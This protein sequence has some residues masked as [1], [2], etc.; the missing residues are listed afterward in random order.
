MDPHRWWRRAKK[1]CGLA[2]TDSIPP[3]SVEGQLHV[4][5]QDRAACLNS[6]FAS[7]CSA[8]PSP[9]CQQLCAMTSDVF[10]FKSLSEPD[11]LKKL[12]QLD[13]SKSPGM[14]CL[15]N[16]VLKECA[17]TLVQP[18]TFMFNLSLQCGT[19]P[20]R[21]KSAIIQPIFKNRG[22]RSSP[23]SYRP[24]ALLPAVSKV[25]ERLVR[26]QL[27]E[28]C[29]A[30]D[31]IPECQF[32]FLP[33]RSTV[34]QLLAVLEEWED[35][36]DNGKTVHS[37]FL[38]VAKAFDRVDHSLLLMKLRSIGVVGAPLSWMTSYLGNRCIS[39]RV[40]GVCLTSLP[41]SS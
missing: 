8:P 31:A 38:D 16:R 10:T 20:R 4:S 13:C 11:V 33:Q 27:L 22:D 7:Q 39:T 30:V 36:V 5:P 1:A 15:H 24:I 23:S 2:A 19:F 6:V 41:I 17:S 14:D 26:E 28:H 40:D 34:W 35:A 3:L 29:F 37:C 12:V 25:L 9:P 21:W 32:G 18:L